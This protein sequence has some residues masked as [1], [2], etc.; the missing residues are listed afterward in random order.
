MAERLAGKVALISGAAVFLVS[1]ESSFIT[2]AEL[3]VDGGYTAV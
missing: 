3:N 1:D 2:G